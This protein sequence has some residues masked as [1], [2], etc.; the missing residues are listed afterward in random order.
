[1][2]SVAGLADRINAHDQALDAA[3]Q[4]PPREYAPDAPDQRFLHKGRFSRTS[5][6]STPAQEPFTDDESHR[7]QGQHIFARSNLPALPGL[8]HELY[9]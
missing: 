5:P 8:G 1:M 2:T 6:Q 7:D 3:A 9:L 4:F